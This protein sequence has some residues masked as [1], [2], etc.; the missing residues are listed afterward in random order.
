[1][2]ITTTTQHGCSSFAGGRDQRRWGLLSH[3]SA[4]LALLALAI[5]APAQEAPSAAPPVA[6]TPELATSPIAPETDPRIDRETGRDVRNWPP[7]PLFDYLHMRL[8]MV[9]PDMTETKFSAVQTLTA[10]PIAV[11]RSSMTLDAG[12]GLTITG[13][14][15]DGRPVEFSHDKEA[16]R[17]TI[18]FDRPRTPDRD[19]AVR[20]EYEASKPGGGGDG[21]TWSRDDPRTPEFDWM[22]HSQGQPEHNHLWFPCHDFPNDRLTSE[23]I[24]TLPAPYEAVSNGRLIGVKR[25]PSAY[26]PPPAHPPGTGDDAGTADGSEISATPILLPTPATP[27]GTVTYHWLQDK[28]HASYLVALV[29]GRFDVIN[30]GGPDSPTPGLSVPVYGPLGSGEALRE[31]FGNTPAMIKH[32]AELFDSP[33]PWDKY[34]QVMCRNFSAGA[35]ENTSITTFNGNLGRG[36]RGSRDDIIAHELVHQWFGDLVGY[37]SWEHLWLGEGWATMGEA[38]WAEHQSGEDGYQEA[39]IRNMSSERATSG[40]RFWPRHAPMVSNRYRNPDNRFTSGDNVYQKGGA[41]LHMLRMRL[42]DDVFWRGTRLYLKRHAFQQVETDQFR[43][44]MEEV[45]G[46]SLERFFDQ[47]C[48]RPGHPSLEI[49]YQWTP[50]PDAAPGEASGGLITVTVEQVQRIDADNP[51]YAFQLP[52]YAQFEGEGGEYVY[53]T[54]DSRV[55]TMTFPLARRPASMSV[56]PYLTVLARKRVR[57]G[58]DAAGHQLRSGPTLASRLQAIETLAEIRRPAALRT[59]LGVIVRGLDP[60]AGGPE[61][62]LAH[63]AVVRVL[64]SVATSRP[65][66]APERLTDRRDPPV[67]IHADAS[68]APHPHPHLD[69]VHIPLDPP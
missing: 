51:A 7:D 38:L 24:I 65:I 64:D 4:G 6:E 22:F 8:E 53:L 17:L 32:F 47:W 1:M 14:R 19:L 10:R 69:R 26:V 16:S 20:L 43:L 63:E 3:A 30:L 34:G 41:V 55:T 13:A 33:Y 39:I 56:D 5:V 52:I 46:Q 40:R 66:R 62:W 15:L 60:D 31:V 54:C 61:Q 9:V 11:A 25:N 21:L 45:S 58:L 29:A 35:M 57:Q 48:R 68:A 67:S 36:R 12:P 50:A 27:T 59:I 18:T 2:P 49:D 44:C 42:G 23:I 37:R 28:P